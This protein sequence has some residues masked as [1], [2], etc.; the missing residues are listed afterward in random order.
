MKVALIT[1]HRIHNY[2]SVL[3]TYASQIIFERL[4][5]DTI[6][7]DYITPQRTKKRLFMAKPASYRGG[8]RGVLLHGARIISLML[9]DITFGR[10]RQKH[11]KLTRKYITPEDLEK[12]PPKADVYVTGSDQVWNSKYNEG[13]DHGFFLDFI[14]DHCRRI[15]FCASFGKPELPDEEKSDIERYIR[16]YEALSVREESAQ[17]ILTEMGRSDAVQLVDPTLQIKKEEWL[18]IAKRR[19]IAEPYVLLM[20]LYGEDN[21]AT[22]Y[23]RRIADEKE[24]KLVKLS[25]EYAKPQSVDILMTHRS[26]EDFLSLIAYADFIVTNSF[27]GVAFSINLEKQF[28]V[29]PRNEFN[30]RIESLLDV[31][32]LQTRMKL[33]RDC[34][35]IAAESIDYEPVR[36]ILEHE[37]LRAQ[38]FLVAHIGRGDA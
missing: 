38:E 6:V 31:T 7:I 29:V 27:H 35:A 3:Q 28:M 11:L 33:N 19:L 4:G 26:P 30:T 9:R 24:I 32:G 17:K 20:L 13:I 2:G 5:H 1:L 25:W 18:S 23:A 15:A 14:P 8:V 36:R 21:Q 10:F 16:R 34:V 12:N 37:R 22:A